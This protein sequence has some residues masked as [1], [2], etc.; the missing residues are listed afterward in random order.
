MKGWDRRQYELEKEGGIRRETGAIYL[1]QLKAKHLRIIALHLRGMSNKK[2]AL[3]TGRSEAWI[4]T[5][6]SDPLSKRY[7]ERFRQQEEGRLLGLFS[8]SIDAVEESLDARLADARPNHGVRLKGADMAFKLT[9]AY[10]IADEQAETA[11]DVV[12]RILQVNVQV[13]NNAAGMSEG[14]EQRALTHGD[15]NSND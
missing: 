5:V 15:N 4:S 2:V 3:E 13:N 1:K 10:A 14:E 11:E 8:R 12:A 9:G 6:L 7:L